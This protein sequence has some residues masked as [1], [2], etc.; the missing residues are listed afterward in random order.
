VG[1]EWGEVSDQVA[2][3]AAEWRTARSERQ[4]RR[5]L[6]RDDFDRLRS[7]GLLLSAVPTGS[8]GL[9]EDVARS[10][11]PISDSLRTLARGDA[12]VALVSAMHPAVI[13]FWLARDGGDEAWHDQRDAVCATAAA[14]A[15]WGTI[16]SEPG[17]GGDITRTISVARPDPDGDAFIPGRTYR[18]SGTKHFGSGSGITDFMITTALPDGE[19]APAIFAI[20]VRDRPWDGSAGM[21]LV[22]EWDGMGMAAT[23]SHAM[24]LD[25]C[26]AV[27][28][29]WPGPIEEI[30]LPAAPL[31]ANLFTAVIQGVLDEA[32]ETAKAQLREKA[33]TMRPFEQ[34]EWTRAELDHWMAA[35]AVEGALR[36][37]ETGDHLRALHA[38][39]RAKQ[40]VAELAESTLSRIARVVGGG[41]FSRRSPFASWFEDVRALGFLRPPWGLAFDNLFA[42]SLL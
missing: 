20:D 12:S 35:Q 31:V 32:V 5:H 2:A 37:V 8:G 18:L 1:S 25:G 9:W 42:T 3:V 40:G 4:A 36:A 38:A 30:T 17:S 7:A 14:G 10:T 27:R 34:V 16:T 24:A 19:D 39:L 41:T 29:A 6:E 28:M 21:R 13:G 26:P 22:A 15:Q 23:Q 33:P 11:R